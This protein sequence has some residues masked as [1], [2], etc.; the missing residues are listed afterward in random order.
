[1]GPAAEDDVR[2]TKLVAAL[3]QIIHSPV[4]WNSPG[5]PVSFSPFT[6]VGVI[7]QIGEG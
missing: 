1:M 4:R 7:F 5:Q 6:S 3:G 2:A